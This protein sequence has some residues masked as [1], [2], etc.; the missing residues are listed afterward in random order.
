MAV[1]DGYLLIETAVE[2]SKFSKFS[3]KIYIYCTYS[4]LSAFMNFM[5]LP[6]RGKE[7][8]QYLRP[9]PDLLLHLPIDQNTIQPCNLRGS[10]L[11]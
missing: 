8:Q 4:T 10:S 1:R 5:Y 11:S 6:I 2:T 9:I 7:R 3:Y